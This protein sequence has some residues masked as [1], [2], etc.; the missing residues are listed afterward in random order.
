MSVPTLQEFLDENSVLA[1]D[2]VRT[3]GGGGSGISAYWHKLSVELSKNPKFRKVLTLTFNQDIED[4]HGNGPL[5]ARALLSKLGVLDGLDVP[6]FIA[7]LRGVLLEVSAIEV[8]KA[9]KEF[10]ATRAHP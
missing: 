7:G 2:L 3:L 1:N 4:N 10:L 5:R 6:T 9:Y 8:E